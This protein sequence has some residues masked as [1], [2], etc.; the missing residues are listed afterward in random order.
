LLKKPTVKK[1]QGT[2][3]SEQKPGKNKDKVTNRTL[4]FKRTFI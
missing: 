2:S 3:Q 1:S 4:S